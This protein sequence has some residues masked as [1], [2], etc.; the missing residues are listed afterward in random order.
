ML[1]LWVVELYLGFYG[2][3]VKFEELFVIIEDD[4]YWFDDDLLYVCCW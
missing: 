1:G 3:G 4:V 2:V